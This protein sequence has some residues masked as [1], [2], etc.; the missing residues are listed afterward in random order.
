ME[1]A[2]FCYKM[3]NI[4]LDLFTKDLKTSRTYLRP[5]QIKA[6]NIASWLLLYGSWVRRT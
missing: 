6:L 1:S 2:F 3:E 5:A 4:F